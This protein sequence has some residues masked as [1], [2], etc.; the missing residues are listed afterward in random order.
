MSDIPYNIPPLTPAEAF[1]Y[2]KE[3]R[4]HV[5]RYCRHECDCLS[6]FFQVLDGEPYTHDQ[7]YQ[8]QN[9]SDMTEVQQREAQYIQVMVRLLLDA[10][11]AQSRASDIFDM[12]ATDTPGA[13]ITYKHDV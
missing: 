12:F 11:L 10:G 7:P 13:T 4:Y 3:H 6:I 9:W 1:T 8:P 5:D 2:I